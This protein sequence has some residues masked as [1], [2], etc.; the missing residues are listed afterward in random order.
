MTPA[1]SPGSPT[2]PIGTILSAS[3]TGAS[4]DHVGADQSRRDAVDR[5]AAAR[6]FHRQRLGGADDSRLGRAV[7]DLTAIAHDTRDRR[8]RHDPRRRPPPDHGHD[9]RMQHIVEAVEIRA[10]NRVP[11]FVG[12]RRKCAI[13]RH[14][15]VA[16]HAVIR[17]MG[18]DIRGDCGSAVRAVRD[19]EAQD[20]RRQAAGVHDGGARFFG[21]RQVFAA[22]QDHLKA[23]GRQAFGNGA[24]DAPAGAGHQD[25]AVVLGALGHRDPPTSASTSLG[26]YALTSP[27]ASRRSSSWM[28]Q[29]NATRSFSSRNRRSARTCSVAPER[30]PLGS[31]LC[32][33]ASPAAGRC[34]A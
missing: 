22:M 18:R 16:D 20:A 34:S 24:A 5:D 25:A 8:Q 14:A 2:R 9:R 21:G 33:C 10:Q 32:N 29:A 17:A 23:A 15:G 11:V 3:S 12:E 4:L 31:A 7:I 26:R 19:V 28:V 6:E 1:T 30:E 13:P 27:R